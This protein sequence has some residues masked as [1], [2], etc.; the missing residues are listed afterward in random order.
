MKYNLK[1]YCIKLDMIHAVYIYDKYILLLIQK[2]TW[3]N[4]ILILIKTKVVHQVRA[5]LIFSK[6]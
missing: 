1:K 2:N 4:E 6:V 5:Y 3:Y